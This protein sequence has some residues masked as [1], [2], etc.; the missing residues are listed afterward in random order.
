MAKNDIKL[1]DAGGRSAVPTRIFAVAASATI[2]YAGEPV[3]VETAA[4]TAT[5]IKCADGDP[6]IGTTLQIVG[7]AAKDST[8]TAA[9]AGYVEVYTPCPNDVV[10]GA[11]PKVAGAANTQAKIDALLN[12]CLVLDL[13][14]STFTVD[15]AAGHGNSGGIQVVGGNPANDEIHFVF[16]SDA[17]KTAIS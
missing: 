2:I 16:R 10:W 5:V 12:D 17:C 14:S 15:A 13:T 8:N 6:V 1:V 11:K 4:G 3:K 7:V 9:A